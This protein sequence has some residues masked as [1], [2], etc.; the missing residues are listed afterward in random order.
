MVF[1]FFLSFVLSFFSWGWGMFFFGS[2]DYG[3][4]GRSFPST[5][6]LDSRLHSVGEGRRSGPRMWKLGNE[7]SKISGFCWP[8][9]RKVGMLAIGT[10]QRTSSTRVPEPFFMSELSGAMAPHPSLASARR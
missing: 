3:S 6:A 2:R 4:T 8:S 1:L 10:G 5:T 7:G 9:Q